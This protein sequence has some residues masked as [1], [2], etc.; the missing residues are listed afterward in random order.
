[1]DPERRGTNGRDQG[2]GDPEVG[3]IVNR[4][5]YFLAKFCEHFVDSGLKFESAA[6]ASP[7]L[8]IQIRKEIVAAFKPEGV[9][10]FFFMGFQN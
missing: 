7:T 8:G 1:M 9:S 10:L 6:K 3:V 4:A 5:K 2:R